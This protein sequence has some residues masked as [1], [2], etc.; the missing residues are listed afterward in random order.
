MDRLDYFR[1]LART[2]PPQRL[3][4]AAARRILRG[5]RRQGPAPAGDDEILA[6]FQARSAAALPRRLA[7]PVPGP[8]GFASPPSV[9]STARALRSHLPDEAAQAV[10]RAE[11]ALARRTTVFGHE[12][13]LA[14]ADR[15]VPHA[16]PG[17]RAI[18]WEVCP[19]SGVRFDGR[20]T[21]PDADVKFPWC[22]GRLDEVVHLACGA[23]LTAAEAS[24][25]RAFADAALDRVLDLA[26][27]PQGV[28]WTCAMEVALRAANVAIALRL[29]AGHPA[30]EDRA[31]ALLAILRSLAFHLRWVEAHLEDAVAVPNNHLVS[32]LAGLAVVGALLP[33]LPGA[34]Q[35]ARAALRRLE[36]ELLDQTLPDGFCFEGSVPY[37]RLAVEL[38]VLADLAATSLAAPFGH[39]A[40]DRLQAMFFATRELQDGRGLAPQIGDNDSGRAWPFRPRAPQEQAY[41]LPVGVALFEQQELHVSPACAELVWL[42][43]A[44]GLRRLERVPRGRAPIDSGLCHAGLYVL[45]SRRITCAVAAGPNGTG[46]TGTHGHNDK[47]A[48][49]I[50]V[51]GRLAVGDPGTGSYT[52]DPQLRN[53]L[54]GTAAHS[55]VLVEGHEQQPLPAG[56]LFA[57]PDT[58]RARCLRFVSD[59]NRA[60][61]TCEHRGYERLSPSV[62]HE[63]EVVLDR[64]AE[65]LLV[66]DRLDGVGSVG[67]Q[68]RFLVPGEAR[69]RALREVER[70]R[71]RALL[72]TAHAWD[73]DHAVEIGPESAPLALLVGAG[74]SAP[75]WI[76]QSVYA[77][78]YGEIEHALHVCFP[79][80]R[81]LPSFFTVALLPVAAGAAAGR[82]EEAGSYGA[83]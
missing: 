44:P 14:W 79:M 36:R 27:A 51:D 23:V 68:A 59:P 10:A 39:E 25:S 49:E 75:A 54:R 42:L 13:E 35:S 73:F 16:S 55:T 67:A 70:A 63:R 82:R 22:V 30:L 38:Y 46:G 83:A 28:Q 41:L 9:A 74:A 66:H 31:D 8:W 81:V 61:V 76:E 6:A 34:A 80:S 32:D 45:R 72:G 24:R 78:G 20:T 47:L 53:R 18:D 64:V 21:P 19:R 1:Y 71:L 12:V 58:A 62:V 65:C 29:L 5:A 60:S 43:G 2:V 7:A 56:R 3:A 69:L 11:A 48:V 50:C 52:G 37:H 57:L 77:R 33:R 40:R 17:W 4:A 15:R 26:A